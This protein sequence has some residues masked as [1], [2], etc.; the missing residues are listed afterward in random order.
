ML[1]C[2]LVGM[3]VRRMSVKTFVNHA[4]LAGGGKGALAVGDARERVGTDLAA[5]LQPV[6]RV[7]APPL[8]S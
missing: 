2:M 3:L 5:L 8:G 6:D 4:H 7:P 1:V